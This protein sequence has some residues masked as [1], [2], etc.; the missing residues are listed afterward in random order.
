MEGESQGTWQYDWSYLLGTPRRGRAFLLKNAPQPCHRLHE[1]SGYTYSPWWHSLWDLTLPDG[2]AQKDAALKRGLLE[3]DQE[4]DQCLE[5]AATYSM[6]AQLR[7]LFVTILLFNEPSNPLDLWDKYKASLAEDFLCHAKTLIPD[8]VLNVHILNKVLLDIGNRLQKHGKSL[9]DFP[10]MPIPLI[11]W[12]LKHKIFKKWIKAWKLVRLYFRAS[13]T[14]LGWE[15]LPP[16]KLWPLFSIF[17][18]SSINYSDK[19]PFSRNRK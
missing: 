5:E 16:N 6:P 2:T 9:S 18:M 11:V 13:W 10:N 15:P 3:D 14:T 17:Q 1:L 12:W 4:S 19:S 7:Q 8:I